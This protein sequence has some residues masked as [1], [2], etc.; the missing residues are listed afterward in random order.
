MRAST[1]RSMAVACAEAYLENA[2]NPAQ[3]RIQVRV[4]NGKGVS[5]VVRVY[6]E[7]EEEETITEENQKYVKPLYMEDT[8]NASDTTIPSPAS[9]TDT[10][11]A[12][13]EDTGT[14]KPAKGKTS[15]K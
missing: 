12:G 1:I 8:N 10:V 15:P 4:K 11:K 7:G 2:D 6:A 5:V 13:A 3:E 9:I 14:N